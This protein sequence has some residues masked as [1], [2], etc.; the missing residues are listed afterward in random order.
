MKGLIIK[1]E[2]WSIVP[3]RSGSKGIKKK[4]LQKILGHSLLKL[5]VKASLKSKFIRRTFVST[6]SKVFKKEALRYGAEV[7]FLRS[8]KNSSNTATD[9]Q[10]MYEFLNNLIKTFGVIPK[11]FILLL[12][13]SPFRDPK[14]LDEA[15]IKFKRIKNYDSLVSVYPMEEPVQKKFFIKKKKIETY[16]FLH[17]FG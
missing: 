10:V 17:V 4:N 9:F 13:T 6:D 5:A 7:P 16:I 15:I 1:N 11:Y 12:P 8:K 2:V 14:I 3:A